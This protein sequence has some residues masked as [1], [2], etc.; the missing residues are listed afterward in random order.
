MH[1]DPQGIFAA[2]R[3]LLTINYSPHPEERSFLER[4]HTQREGEVETTVAVPSN[5][6][7]ER[8][9]GVR[10]S[11]RGL[12]AVWLE[13]VNGRAEPLWLDRVQIDPNYF[14]P[15]EAAQLAH[16]AMGRR[17]AAFGLL[18]WLFLPLLPFIPFKL[19]GVRAANRRMNNLFR[20][21]G[22]PTGVIA[23]GKR[24]NGFLFTGVDEGVKRMRVRLLGCN[25]SLE[26][27]FTV[28]IPGLALS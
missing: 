1:L 17:L 7:S 18:G 12:Q 27:P 26:F 8:I 16:F 25:Q 13:I 5:H 28:E 19:L 9:F 4:A 22:F 24:V 2:A 21:M 20:T 23:S 3:R 11:N 6:E 15:F 14:T 10:L